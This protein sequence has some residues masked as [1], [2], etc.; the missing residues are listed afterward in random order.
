MTQVQKSPRPRSRRNRYSHR[1]ADALARLRRGLRHVGGLVPWVRQGA[2]V[3]SCEYCKHYREVV[4][5]GL[6]TREVRILPRTIHVCERDL[7]VPKSTFDERWPRFP[8]DWFNGQCG[9]RAR[10]FAPK[11]TP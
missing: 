4:F 1:G 9:H 5:G 6:T 7:D 10:F 3:I 8:F 2:A 11:G